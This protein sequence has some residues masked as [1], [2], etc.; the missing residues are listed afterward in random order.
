[1]PEFNKFEEY[2]LFIDDTARLSDRRQL[3]SNIYLTVNS[4]LLA[5]IGIIVKDLGIKGSWLLLLPLPLIISGIAVCIFWRQLILR[6]KKL[7]KIR[8]EAL[9]DMED[10][11][12]MEGSSMIY[13]E[14]SRIYERDAQGQVRE[15]KVKAFSDLEL[16]LPVLFIVLYTLFGIGLIAALIYPLFFASSVNSG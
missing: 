15:R 7:I 9:Y 12:E 5:A 8:M 11:A 16:R 3:I 10:A 2:K 6:Y 13:H 14:E 1:M 4:L